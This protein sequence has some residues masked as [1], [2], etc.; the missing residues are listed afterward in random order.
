MAA[1]TEDFNRR[2]E[3][4][5]QEIL[6]IRANRERIAR[7]LERVKDLSQKVLEDLEA[8]AGSRSQV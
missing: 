8:L 4:A 7:R 6:A 1:Q 2:R 5:R 3:E